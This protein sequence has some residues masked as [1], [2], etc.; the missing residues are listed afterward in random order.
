MVEDQI[1]DEEVRAILYRL[2]ERTERMDGQLERMS[3]RTTRLQSQLSI[4]ETTAEQNASDI[5]RN[6]TIINAL[7]FGLGAGL[8]TFWAKIQGYLWV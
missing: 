5:R 3:D 2:D 1:E 8:T 4:V 7:T 6:S